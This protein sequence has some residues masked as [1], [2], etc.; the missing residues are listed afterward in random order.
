MHDSCTEVV[1]LAVPIAPTLPLDELWIPFGSSKQVRY[2]PAHIIA[3]SLG[4][5]K[6]GVLSMFHALTGCDIVSFFN[7]R[8]KKTAWDVWNVFPELAP[9]LK[10][11]LML[12]EDIEDTCLDVIERIV[13]HLPYMTAIAASAKSMKSGKSFSQERQD[14]LRTSL[15]LRHPYDNMLK[16][17]SS[18]VVLYGARPC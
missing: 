6:A 17:L 4:R 13:I 11:M 10:A 7:G 14:P 2:L 8:G 9:V 16:E 5:E 15:P 12:P 3:T 1:V 18:K